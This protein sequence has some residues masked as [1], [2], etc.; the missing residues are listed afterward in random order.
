MGG[1]RSMKLDITRPKDFCIIAT[2]CIIVGLILG[3]FCAYEFYLASHYPCPLDATRMCTSTPIPI[4][5]GIL[6]ILIIV[7]VAAGWVVAA[8]CVPRWCRNYIERKELPGWIV[9]I[10]KFLKER[11][12]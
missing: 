11:A 9:S 2:L 1:E 6:I 8:V 4:W 10:N 7:F 5:L 12:K 3:Q